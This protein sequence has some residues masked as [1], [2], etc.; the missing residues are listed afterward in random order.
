MYDYY[1][2]NDMNLQYR[3]EV[4]ITEP[5]DH[6]YVHSSKSWLILMYLLK[7]EI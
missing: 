3:T 6:F 1:Y 2:Y 7:I 4:K 5:I